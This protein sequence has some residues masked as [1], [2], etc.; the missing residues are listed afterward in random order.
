[1]PISMIDRK[2]N[3]FVFKKILCGLLFVAGCVPFFIWIGSQS[4]GDENDKK[5]TTSGWI[6][7][8]G[9]LVYAIV[10]LIV[11]RRPEDRYRCPN[12]RA[13]RSRRPAR[14]RRRWRFRT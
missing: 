10:A 14:N 2:D 8:A 3:E 4:Y 5:L 7:I 12:C 11:I 1:M 6:G 13:R 9:L